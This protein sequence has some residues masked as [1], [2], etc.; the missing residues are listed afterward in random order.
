MKRTL[1]LS[2]L[3]LLS[4]N[5][6]AADPVTDPAAAAPV[7]TA[8]GTDYAHNYEMIAVYL[9]T[10]LILL[11]VARALLHAFKVVAAEYK[12]PAPLAEAAPVQLLEYEEWEK[13]QKSKPGL[14]SKLMGLRPISEE[15]DIMIEHEFDGITELD[16]PTPAWFMWLFYGSIAFG[17]VYVLNY[18]VF[19][20]SPLQ[21][22]E[23]AIEVKQ[24]AVEKEA[25]L[26]KAGN[27]I[28]ENNVKLNADAAVLASGKS[29]FTANCVACH[30]E[31]AQGIVGPNL[32]DEFWLHGGKINNVFKTIKYGIPEKGMISWEKTLSPKQI[33]EVANYV[34]SLQG[35]HPQNAKAPQGEK[36]VNK[37]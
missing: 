7:A 36:E 20:L 2:F 18:H 28:D 32:T 6:F 8:A 26:A 19:N 37:S 25:Y 11:A 4:A 35:S 31:N 27:L 24:A 9:F 17:F 33:S 29:L 10:A 34:L 23:Y 12:N 14:I 22:E 13:R 3:L 5:A 30:G 1:Y 15:K 16:N 21:D